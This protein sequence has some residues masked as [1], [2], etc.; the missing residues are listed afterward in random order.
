M[1][2][3]DDPSQPPS[4][5][6]AERRQTESS[7]LKRTALLFIGCLLLLGTLIGF[8]LRSAGVRD[9]DYSR[10]LITVVFSFGTIAVALAL[11]L[12]VLLSRDHALPE[13]QARFNSGKEV[14]A[15]LLGIF[16]TIVGFY[17]GSITDSPPK[18]LSVVE[19]VV[20]PDQP[21]LGEAVTITVLA[22]GGKLP[23]DYEL[24][25]DGMEKS[26][27]QV[28]QLDRRVM[29]KKVQFDPKDS[30][31]IINVFVV[32]STGDAAHASRKITFASKLQ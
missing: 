3:T 13:T 5:D 27:V 7:G 28:R 17:F 14:L 21:V 15:L 29:S 25:V 9:V 16:G 8:L 23:L 6:G 19:I 1:A 18:P 20:S 10:G 2:E 4:P 12:S 11:V 26:D 30:V 31:Q 24:K 22:A 32:D